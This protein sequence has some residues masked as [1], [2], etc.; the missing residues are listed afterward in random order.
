MDPVISISDCKFAT[1]IIAS[2]TVLY[3]YNAN[4]AYRYQ[5]SDPARVPAGRF[6]TA[7]QHCFYVANHPVAALFEL[8][9]YQPAIV[10]CYEH[11]YSVT[12]DVTVVDL[13]RHQFPT[14]SSTAEKDAKYSNEQIVVNQ[15]VTCPRGEDQPWIPASTQTIADHFRSGEVGGIL[16]QTAIAHSLASASDVYGDP[17][18]LWNFALFLDPDDSERLLSHHSVTPKT[19]P[20][21]VRRLYSENQLTLENL[22]ARLKCASFTESAMQAVGAPNLKPSLPLY[23]VV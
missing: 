20:K 12:S 3:R 2:G 22:H 15:H 11:V 23:R 9:S 16:Y 17:S 10:T 6:N 7:G 14:P 19:V 18:Q 21:K 5:A 1:R 8:M 13:G 4:A